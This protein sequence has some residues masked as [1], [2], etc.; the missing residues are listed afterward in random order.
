MPYYRRAIVPGG[1][2]FFTVVTYGRQAILTKDDVR[3]A[4]REAIDLVRGRQPF[5]I[6][7]WVLLPDHMHTIW[8]LPEGD[9]DFSDR[10][11]LIKRHVA[12]ACPSYH[13]PELLSGRR[14]AKN[15]SSLWQNRFW[16]H[17][18]RDEAD[19]RSHLDYLHGNPLKHGLVQ[20]VAD[21]PWSS[22]HRYVRRGTYPADWGGS[23]GSDIPGGE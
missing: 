12:A 5:R 14:R 1:T 22:F 16:E 4:L 13:R 11:R 9:A 19:L 15:Q 18:I 6:D 20:R 10:W 23:K 7:G 21:W 2:Y 17:L 3:E 8:T